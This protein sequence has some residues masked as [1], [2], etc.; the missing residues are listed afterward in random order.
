MPEMRIL[1]HCWEYPPRGSGIGQYIWHMSWALRE[2]GCYVVVVTSYGNEGPSEEEIDNGKIYRIYRV[3]DI[4]KQ[5]IAD[6]LID[7]A[8]KHN[9]DWI[10]GADH[11]GETALLLQYSVRPHVVI[12]A[13]YN[14]VLRT[15]RYAHAYHFWQRSLI[16]LACFRDRKRIV[17]E[18]FSLSAPDILMAPS[19]RILDELRN[20]QVALA[21]KQ[22]VVP[23]P[24]KSL[25]GWRNEES[26]LP[27]ILL[28]GRIDIGKGVGY[29]PGIVETLKSRFEQFAI[30]IAGGDGYARLIGS[31]KEWLIEKMGEDVKYLR[32]LGQLGREELDEAYSRAWVVVVPSKWDTFPTVVLEAMQRGKAIVASENGGMS[33][34]LENTPNVL[35]KPEST[36]FSDA[37]AEFLNNRELREISGIKG[38]EKV[39]SIYSPSRVGQEYLKILSQN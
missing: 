18:R 8:D 31:I 2:L 14:D 37:V 9:I 21:A 17:R 27:T 30:E 10:E 5:W 29:L 16:N 34:M 38:K 6:K 4:G 1:F 35:A 19:K 22:F 20:Q 3:E 36:N 13:H 23:N 7:I 11:L 24:I 12:K 26:P 15:S 39:T 25:N 32:F 28:V 33:E